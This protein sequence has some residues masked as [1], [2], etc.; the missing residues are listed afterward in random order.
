[1]NALRTPDERFADLPDFPWPPHYVD[2]LPGLEGLR[3]AFLDEGP[4]NAEHVFLCLHG[5]PTW[6]FLYRKM[7]PVFLDAGA[8]VVAPDF[9]GFGRSDKPANDEDYTVPLH[10]ATILRLLERLDLN[11]IT[12]VCQDWGGLIGLT[13]PLD[14]PDRFA[15]LLVMNTMFPIASRPTE[16]FLA[17]RAYVEANPDFPVGR[18]LKRSAPT[19]TEAEVAAY[20]APFPDASYKGGVRTFPALVPVGDDA[21]PEVTAL[22]ERARDWWSTMW[23]GPTFMAV[24]TQDPVLGPP[25]MRWMQSQ[26]RGCP[27]PMV[28]DDAGHFVQEQGDRV[29]RAALRAWA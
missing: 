23:S 25:V 19:L 14:Q 1:M 13:L 18:L 24:G 2:D 22:G 8:R 4:K 12:L 17:W 16:G 5:E 21:D 29:A 9:L 27:A 28:L 11:R 3:V 10:R 26:I 15:R 6:S 7:I 20:E